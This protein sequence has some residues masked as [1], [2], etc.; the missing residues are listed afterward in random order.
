MKRVYFIP[1]PLDYTSYAEHDVADVRDFLMERFDKFPDTARIYHRHLAQSCDVT[2]SNEYQ[3]EQLGVLEGPF[4]VVVYPSGPLTIV[5]VVVTVLAVAAAFL[6]RPKINVPTPVLR[7]G[8][9][10]QTFQSPNNELSARSNKPRVNG[11][12]PDIFGC[13][14]STPDLITP[15]YRVFRNNVEVEYAYMCI[16]K[17]TYLVE[18]VR[19]DTTSMESI[20]GSTVEIFAPET[21]PNNTT[22]TVQ[23]RV[24]GTT[25]IDEPL[26]YTKRANSVDG[27]VLRAP[28]ANKI[29]GANDIRF[30]YPDTIALSSFSEKD[31]TAFFEVGDS[32]IVT[33]AAGDTYDLAGT[34]DVLDVAQFTITLADPED[35]NADWLVVAGLTDGATPFLSPT[36]AT[37]GPKWVG[38]FI[39]DQPT[40]THIIANFVAYNGLYKDDGQNQTSTSVDIELEITPV[41]ADG[42][43][44][45]GMSAITRTVTIQG[46]AQTRSA[47]A[48]TLTTAPSVEVYGWPSRYSVRARR[49]SDTDFDFAGTVVD[50]VK[51][52]D[53]YSAFI[54]PEPHFGNVTTVHA[55][56]IATAGALSV[57]DRKLNMLVTRCLPQYVGDG[58][59][60]SG[61]FPTKSAADI[62]SFVCLDPNIGNRLPDECDFDNFY[63]TVAD[64]IA[65]FG[66]PEVGE[67]SY[68]FD[69]DNLSFEET[70]TLIANAVFCTPYRTGSLIRLSFEQSTEDSTLLFNHRNKLPGSEKRTVRF[71]T[72]KD[73]DGV[74]YTYVDPLDDSLITFHIPED[75]SAANPERIESV[76]IRTHEQAHLHAWRI[77]NR[78]RYQNVGVEFIA[79]QEADMLVLNDR[80][81]NADNT[82]SDPQANGEIVA[83]DGLV[84]ELS[85]PVTLAGGPYTIFLQLADGTVQAIAVSAGVDSRHA[86][87]A[88]PPAL[89]LVMDEESYAKTTYIL[90]SNA[91]TL[92]TAFLVTNKRV[93]SNFTFTVT[94]VNYDERYYAND[95]DFA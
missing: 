72:L 31:F 46:S 74:A 86:V 66:I 20:A 28:N 81:L 11:R 63:A 44:V 62:L 59:F 70:A 43:V 88:A 95:M 53:V 50:E 21:S 47:R 77:W 83:Q 76:G 18:D 61:L 78:I 36:V 25:P 56:T 14:R 16:G 40:T 51:W 10:N 7:L 52:R 15:P 67:F 68:T 55:V 4:Y 38:P 8:L 45:S 13:V 57:K 58:A 6:L 64:V 80:I 30:V 1:N 91:E 84:I 54:T 79:T 75:Q 87:L 26:Y 42:T 71:G 82:R 2:P 9:N 33:N 39:L 93:E 49:T 24:G 94:A 12:I 27:Q 69:S 90:V 17:G 5:L 73:S 35:V 19:D 41:E 32:I 34:Y 48:A 29:I 23:L 85:Q 3:I 22:G 89:P 65:Y 92:P 60:T 37:V